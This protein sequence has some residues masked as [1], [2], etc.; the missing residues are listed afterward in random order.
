MQKLGVPPAELDQ[1]AAE[2]REGMSKDVQRQRALG[3]VGRNAPD[4]WAWGGPNGVIDG[5]LLLYA[6]ERARLDE[7]EERLTG[8]QR[9]GVVALYRLETRPLQD[10]P[11]HRRYWFREHFGFRDGVAQPRLALRT[12]A[13][14]ALRRGVVRP[15]G[16][17]NTIAPGEFIFGYRNEYGKEPEGAPARLRANGSFLVFRQIE[18]DVCGFWQFIRDKARRLE[19]NPVLLASK[20]VGRW[21]NGAPLVRAPS[22]ETSGLEQFDSFGYAATDPE[23]HACPFGAHVRRANPRDSLVTGERQ[24]IQITKT[25]RIV[26]RGRSYGEPIHE[27]LDPSL[28]L[29]KIDV[30]ARDPGGPRGLY[31][32]CFNTNIR[33]QFEF[34]QQSW[35]NSPKFKGQHDGADPIAAPVDGGSFEIP[36]VPARRR[37]TDMRTF[38]RVRGGAYFFMPGMRA[39]RAIAAPRP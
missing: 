7:L 36:G 30:L 38:V 22:E 6:S 18:Q 16:P 37:V 5:V 24:S 32:L 11:G 29:P 34:V 20:M 2:L 3:D 4:Q 28:F 27:P 15:A 26:R 12:R 19:M 1:F 10:G 25:H 31:F 39:L 21:P 23:G 33:R 35:I 13:P 17:G 14:E 9:T 8:G